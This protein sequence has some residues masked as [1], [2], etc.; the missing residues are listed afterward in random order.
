MGFKEEPRPIHFCHFRMSSWVLFVL[1]RNRLTSFMHPSRLD[2]TLFTPPCNA[3]IS[4]PLNSVASPDRRR[5]SVLVTLA[6]SSWASS[7]LARSESGSQS[8][9][10]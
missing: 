4:D 10:R 5:A 3:I 7:G 6:R 2:T 9:A 8:G 1:R